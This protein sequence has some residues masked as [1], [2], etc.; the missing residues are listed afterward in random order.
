MSW[1]VGAWLRGTGGCRLQGALARLAVA[2]GAGG[3]IGGGS[4]L[5]GSGRVAGA[6]AAALL[7]RAAEGLVQRVVQARHLGGPQ[8]RAGAQALHGRGHQRGQAPKGAAERGHVRAVDAL[9]RG[10]RGGQA[11]AVVAVQA[12]LDR[13]RRLALVRLERLQPARRLLRAPRQQQ[14][15]VR[16]H[17]R[18]GD[19]LQRAHAVVG[20]HL[21]EQE[22]VPEGA[23]RQEAAQPGVHVLR[24][25][26]VVAQAH[27][28]R[29]R[30]LAQQVVRPA[31]AQPR[32]R[33]VPH[34]AQVA[35]QRVA[36]LP[37]ADQDRVWGRLQR[38]QR[39]ARRSGRGGGGAVTEPG[40]RLCML[41]RLRW[42]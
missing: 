23:A 21:R 42:L 37:R 16:A 25:Q 1:P 26:Q 9:E 32:V 24:V 27:K 3:G 2:A 39:R 36:H 31:G 12:L 18:L 19:G 8:P 40:H 34:R 7:Q 4:L 11:A 17:R 30:A 14:R 41:H 28:Q 5:V 13:V 10:E 35:Q 38:S 15:H 22:A 6:G 20:V 33:R 29:R